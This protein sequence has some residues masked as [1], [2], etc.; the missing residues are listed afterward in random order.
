MVVSVDRR[1]RLRLCVVPW[2]CRSVCGTM[3]VS[4]GFLPCLVSRKLV[5]CVQCVDSVAAVVWRAFVEYLWVCVWVC[6]W[7]HVWVCV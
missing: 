1:T 2:C 3:C 7:V 5:F 4:F 6:V